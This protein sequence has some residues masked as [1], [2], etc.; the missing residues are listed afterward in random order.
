MLRSPLRIGIM[1]LGW[2]A[3]QRHI[4]SILRQPALALTGVIDRHEGRAAAVAKK[5]SLPF[6][7]QTDSFESVTWTDSI[8][9]LLLCTPVQKRGALIASAL[10]K[11]KHV[12]TEKPFA[13]TPKEGRELGLAATQANTTLA[14][15]HNLRFCRSVQKLHADLQQGRLGALHHVELRYKGNSAKRASKWIETLPLGAFFDD[16]P[17]HFYLINDLANG[18]LTLKNSYKTKGEQK[19][20]PRLVH[21]AYQDEASVSFR[22]ECIY[23]SPVQEWFLYAVGDKAIGICDLLRDIYIRTPQSSPHN[24]ISMIRT[25]L[26]TTAQ[27]LWGHVPNGLAFLTGRLDYG[28]DEVIKRFEQSIHTKEPDEKI[29]WE[30]AVAVLNQ[31]QTAIKT[32]NERNEG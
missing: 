24:A 2:V 19:E 6:Y 13:L 5:W 4:P 10:S 20:T 11:G 12:L 9:A 27:H 21:L 29:G 32:L 31:Q 18:A 15:V 16:S 28:N 30:K 23:D 1:G 17:H 26:S 8:D 22:I 3:T 14:V 7:A 25:S